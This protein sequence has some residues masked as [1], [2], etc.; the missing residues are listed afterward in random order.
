MTSLTTTRRHIKQAAAQREQEQRSQQ[1]IT[2]ADHYTAAD[3]ATADN[4]AAAE[5]FAEFLAEEIEV[6]ATPK[7]VHELVKHNGKEYTVR[8]RKGQWSIYIEYEAF[9]LSR[10]DLCRQAPVWR[11]R[12]VEPDGRLGRAILRTLAAKQVAA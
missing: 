12:S 7:E 4:F 8:S 3:R 9:D 5:M 11:I 2:A 10:R 1:A 6:P